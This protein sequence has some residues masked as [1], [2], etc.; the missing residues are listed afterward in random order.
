M[1]AL[2]AQT[3]QA[4]AQPLSLG[5]DPAKWPHS[6]TGVLRQNEMPRCHALLMSI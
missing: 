1:T 6:A 2:Q 3:R 4:Q 5:M